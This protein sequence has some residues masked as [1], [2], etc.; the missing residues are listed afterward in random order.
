MASVR[1]K[2]LLPGARRGHRIFRK[3]GQGKI[4]AILRGIGGKAR[5]NGDRKKKVL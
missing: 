5:F 4:P 2:R 1:E 3:I